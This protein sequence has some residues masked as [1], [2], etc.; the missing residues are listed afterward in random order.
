MNVEV[1]AT[2]TTSALPDVA[3]YTAATRVEPAVLV[4]EL[5]ELL[6]ARL[7]AYLGGVRETSG[8]AAVGR[9]HPNRR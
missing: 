9:R 4:K 3:A 8:G 1:T 5:R 7:V 2:M 6:G